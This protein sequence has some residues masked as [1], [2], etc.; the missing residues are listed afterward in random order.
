LLVALV[1]VLPAGDDPDGEAPS[2][3]L[4]SAVRI[5]AQ[6][7]G[8]AAAAL[9]PALCGQVALAA[10]LA[11]PGALTLRAGIIA[12]M[13]LATLI[14][15]LPLRAE[16]GL[17]LVSIVTVF[18][19]AVRA[20]SGND[21]DLISLSAVLVVAATAL[22]V[23]AVRPGRRWLFLPA[24]ALGSAALDCRMLAAHVHATEAY[25]LLPAVALLAFGV[26]VLRR[27]PEV[28]SFAALGPGLVLGFAPSLWD[29]HLASDEVRITI[30]GVLAAV[31]IVAG[32][33]RRLQAPLLLGAL[34]LVLDSWMQLRPELTVFFHWVPKWAIIA[35]VGVTLL[36][37]GATYEARL[38]QARALRLRISELR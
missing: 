31:A 17:G 5:L 11:W 6:V 15:P 34:A 26:E 14:R 36:A 35:V 25:T 29:A 10:G 32:A 20:R 38:A 4:V 24:W 12:L 19:A 9:V 33:V 13:A 28:R 27:R 16:L 1:M 8:L 18:E 30:I 7:G 22:A 23:L 21:A 37:I 2:A 3:G